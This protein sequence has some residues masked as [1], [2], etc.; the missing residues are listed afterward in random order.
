MVA[1]RYKVAIDGLS[2]SDLREEVINHCELSGKSYLIVDDARTSRWQETS[3]PIQPVYGIGDISSYGNEKGLLDDFEGW[4]TNS[5]PYMSPLTF[6]NIFAQD[7]DTWIR[8]AAEHQ[9]ATSLVSQ[10]AFPSIEGD[11]GTFDQVESPQD[12]AL[13]ESSQEATAKET[14]LDEVDIPGLPLEESERRAKWRAVPQRIRVPIR[15]LRRQ[16]GHC[17]KKVLVNL[18]T[19]AK[20]T[21]P[22]SMQ[23]SSTGAMSVRMLNHAEMHIPYPCR[24]GTRSTTR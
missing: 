17:P 11:N 23:Q 15:R 20:S 7:F 24:N 1:I 14:Q 22:I 8:H 3:I 13:M 16:F 5:Y 12:F 19:T 4:Y 18:L 10:T 2:Y 6:D 9:V 21:K